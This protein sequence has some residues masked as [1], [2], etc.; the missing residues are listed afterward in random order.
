M[1]DK[2]KKIFLF[3][4]IV[5]FCFCALF[6]TQKIVSYDDWWHLKTGEWIWQHKTV[7]HVD[8]FSYTF[9]G[10]KWI[11]YEW[12]FQVVI[13]PLYKLSGFGGLV[14]FKVVVVLL[15]FL[16]LF[17]T[18]REMDQGKK[19]LSI[20]IL[21]IALQ[22]ARG[23]FL[24]RPQ[25][26]SLLFLVLYLYLLALH[27]GE[28]I[29]TR[30]LIFFLLPVHILWANIHG[31]FLLGI[32]LVG[33]Y[34]MGSFVPLALS[35]HRDLKPV[36]QDKRI[37]NFLLLGILLI[38]V[39]LINPYT[40]RIFLI[41]L[42]TAGAQETLRGIAEWVPVDPRFLGVLVVDP[43]MWFR[44]LFLIGAISFLVWRNNLKRIEDVLIFAVFSY[45]AFKHV[46]F[47]GPFALVAAP[48]IVS[49][50]TQ[51]RWRVREW[52]WLSL[53]PLIIIIAFSVNDVR[54]LIR[55]EKLGL[56]VWIHY[57]ETT[58]N[59]LKEHDVRGR[60]FN[61]YGY[62]GY[63]IWHLW[64]DIQ[65]FIDGRAVTIYDQDFFWSY[66]LAYRNK[67]TWEKILERYGIEIVLIQDEREKGYS[68]FFYWLDED[69]DWR[70]VA[71]D[72]VSNLY[73]RK[74]AKF[75]KL[76]E[77]YG[78]HYLRPSDISMEYAK[79]KKDDK[80][81]LEALEHELQVACQRF[82]QNFYPFYYLGIYH[83]IY[84]TKEHFK[85]SEKAFSKAIANC[86]YL[87][88]GYYELGFTLMKL[89][90]YD[91]AIEALRKAMRLSPDILADSYYNLG[92]CLF[93]K[94]EINEAI[95]FLEKYKEKAGFETKV[96]AYRLLGRAYLQRHKLQKALSCFE[97]VGY[98]E[99][100]TWDTLLNMGVAYF[101]LDNLE[102]ARKC[103]ER[104][105]EMN[106][107]ALKIVYNLAVVYEKLGFSER[108]ERMYEEASQIRP[109]TPEEET[110]IQ[111]AREKVKQ[112]NFLN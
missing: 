41:P 40:Y 101:G 66:G 56:G 19:W 37:Q 64:P 104:A 111:K 76:I 52:R 16:I 33:A 67:E 21:F 102:K 100:P 75:N 87:P 92:L 63:I 95:K 32:F 103:F 80:N 50:L 17:F 69:E 112:K 62:G 36:F 55:Q 45:M 8:P 91:E 5:F 71:F 72:D 38:V 43:L 4:L 81:Y 9:Q 29:T 93:E 70:L 14:I 1:R 84:G 65:V 60:I 57:P 96:E 27:R 94:G 22:I 26:F 2:E 97:R 54:T 35:H 106:P 59:F 48:I 20:I 23:G 98:L 49:N 39:S 86:P 18:C 11:D 28:R 7:P 85:E 68:L 83:R 58:V 34:A 90:R 108:A 30:Q 6:A 25:I 12:L 82:P 44:V 77:Q 110:L 51:V 99:K 73:M 61:T 47:C 107:G 78:F 3:F 31:S 53:V 74:G 42:E 109:Q 89:E 79:E 105:M 24:V 10:A 13:Y 15:T 46:R 88:Q